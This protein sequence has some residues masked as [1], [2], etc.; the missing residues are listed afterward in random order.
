MNRRQTRTF[1]AGLA[2]MFLIG[3]YPPWNYVYVNELGARRTVPAGHGGL[4]SPPHPYNEYNLYGTYIDIV[5]LLI[6][7]ALTAGVTYGT[8]IALSDA[9]PNQARLLRRYEIDT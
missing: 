5:R 2:I 8:I 1:L 7:W 4:S 3:L 6:Y 9:N